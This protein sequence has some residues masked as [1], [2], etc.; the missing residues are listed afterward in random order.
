[1]NSGQGKVFVLQVQAPE[2]ALHSQD[3]VPSFQV[4]DVETSYSGVPQM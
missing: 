1:M 4:P 3:D 2:R